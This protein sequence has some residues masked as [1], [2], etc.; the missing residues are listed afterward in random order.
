DHTEDTQPCGPTARRSLTHEPAVVDEL[1][2]GPNGRGPAIEVGLPEEGR[3]RARRCRGA[4][5]RGA[6]GEQLGVALVEADDGVAKAVGG[7]DLAPR[8]ASLS[9][10]LDQLD[11][12]AL[13]GA[14]VPRSAAG[15]ARRHP[16]PG[17]RERVAERRES[18]D[19]YR[20]V[21]RLHQG[22]ERGK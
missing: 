6:L 8:A 17:E 13:K 5:A 1:D 21:L 9:V 2:V 7:E 19:P 10:D 3:D 16:L 14:D 18:L 4:V 11:G 20:R 12:L 15:F 22:V